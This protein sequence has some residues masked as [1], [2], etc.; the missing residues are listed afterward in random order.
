MRAI[1]LLPLLALPAGSRA[2]PSPPGLVIERTVRLTFIDVLDRRREVHRKEVVR[3]RGEDLSITDLTFGERLIIR[4][5]VRKVW[6]ADPLAGTYS[7]LSFDEL[8]AHRKRALEEL[9]EARSRVPG[10]ADENELESILE[11]LDEFAGEPRVE[12]RAE[13]AGR[14]VVVNGDRIRAAVEVDEGLQGEGYFRALA[15]IGAFHPAIAEK[16][17]GLGGFPKKGTIR[18]VLFLDRVVERFEVTAARTAEVTDADFEL[19]AKLRRVP[20]E[21][22]EPAPERRPAKPDAF[23]EDFREDEVDRQNNPLRR[24][25]RNP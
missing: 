6:K 14:E 12:L 8:A 4:S 22:L 11:G 2:E 23:R 17:R 15:N 10:T 16:L 20:L 9:R 25:G 13:G 3:L 24:G 19:P 21:G 1:L 5:S 7:E 18:Y